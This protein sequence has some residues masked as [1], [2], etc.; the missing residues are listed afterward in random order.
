MVA[1]TTALRARKRRWCWDVGPGRDRRRSRPGRHG[2]TGRRASSNRLDRDRHVVR[3]ARERGSRRRESTRSPEANFT[4]MTNA[5][6]GATFNAT[7]NQKML[8]LADKAGLGRVRD[9]HARTGSRRG[10]Q[11]RS[12]PSTASWPTTRRPLPCSPTTSPTSPTPRSS[13]TSRRVNSGLATRDPA[14]FASI[15]L[16]PDYASAGSAR[17]CHLRRIRRTVPERGEAGGVHVRPLQLPVRRPPMGRASSRIS[18]SCARTRVATGIPFG[19]YIQSISYNGHRDTNGPEKRWAALHTLAYGGRGV[20]YFTYW[21]PPQTAENFGNGI[22][23]PSGQRTAQYEDVKAINAQLRGHGQVPRLPRPRPRCST[24]ARSIPGRSHRAPG[25]LVYVL[26]RGSAHGRTLLGQPGC[27]RADRQSDHEAVTES[28]VIVAFGQRQ[29]RDARH[30]DGT[31]DCGAQRLGRSPGDS[32]SRRRCSLVTG[33][34]LHLPGPLPPGPPGA[35]GYFG[36]VRADAGW[37]DVVDSSFGTSRLRLAGWHQ[38]PKEPRKWARTSSRTASG[39]A[40]VR[41]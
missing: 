22:I 4:T 8:E 39:S 31:V 10:D 2:R 14:H 26:E 25:D 6:D 30:R 1:T 3:T 34:L 12:E 24:T 38:C 15:N 17:G 23:D 11:R 13:P 16:F 20:M 28:D 5:C 36:T 18:R 21:T 29:G 35:E 41:I 19:Q 37:L 7:Y 32:H 27:V 40:R 9:R 33:V